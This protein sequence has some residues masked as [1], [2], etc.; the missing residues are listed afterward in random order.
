MTILIETGKNIVT[1]RRAQGLSQER[2]AERA[3]MSSPL[4]QHI[5]G[6][7]RNTTIDTLRRMAIT[8]GAA[9]LTLGILSLPDSG[10]RSAIQKPA[11]TPPQV[12]PFQIGENIVLLRR[13]RG[14]TQREL[15]EMALVSPAHLRDIEHGCANVSIA[16]LKRIAD[17]LEISLPAL[18][19]LGLSD[20]QV[21][22]MV[23]KARAVIDS[24][25]VL[26][27]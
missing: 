13:A 12:R 5:E 18:G 10:I 15:A 14:L 8:L 27:L 24:G 23:H 20:G 3:N 22:D 11:D 7:C 17:S 6:G 26:A 1:L 9:P 25:S 21:L 19:S 16:L 2:A 4:W